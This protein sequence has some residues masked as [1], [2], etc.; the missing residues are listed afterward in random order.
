MLRLHP[1]ARRGSAQ[2]SQLVAMAKS[3]SLAGQAQAS[4]THELW[5]GSSGVDQ[6]STA[7]RDATP[8]K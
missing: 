8:Q 2:G 4:G 6:A 7:H 3:V 5:L 1:G